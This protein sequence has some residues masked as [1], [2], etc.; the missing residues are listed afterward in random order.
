MA[1]FYRISILWRSSQNVYWDSMC[2]D[3][4]YGENVHDVF[5]RAVSPITQTDKFPM[6]LGNPNIWTSNTQKLHVYLYS[7]NTKMYYEV[8]IVPNDVVRVG[9]GEY[10]SVWH[11]Y[12]SDNTVVPLS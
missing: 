7:R 8:S 12:T 1:E 4:V 5:N 11:K 6:D 9:G 2:N 3:V 10:G